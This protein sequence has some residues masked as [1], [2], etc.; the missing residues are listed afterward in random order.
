V[1]V[2]ALNVRLGP[3]RSAPVTNK[4]YWQ[5]RIEVLE[6]RSGWAR[7]S[8]YYDSGVEGR[9]GNVA[10][11]VS[12]AHL[13]AARP[14][15][16]RQPQL[17]RDPRISGIPK[18]GENGLSEVDVLTLYRGARHFLDSGRC[19]RIEWGDKSSSKPNT[20]YVN[21]GGPRNLFF[22]GTDLPAS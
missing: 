11:W 3:S 10:R 21:C 19:R 17:P 9:T 13:S 12:A 4:E 20:Y 16:L 7:V 8:E 5:S 22:K 14:A 6:V 2:P 1:A 15:D 18:V